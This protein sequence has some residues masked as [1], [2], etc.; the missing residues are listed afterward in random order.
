MFTEANIMTYQGINYIRL[1]QATE[2]AKKKIE[3]AE[4]QAKINTYERYTDWGSEVANDANVC[5]DR[6][7]KQLNNLK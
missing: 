4:I 1:D 7:K 3:K 2:I 5:I 6:L